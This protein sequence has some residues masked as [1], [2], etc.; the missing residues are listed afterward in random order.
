MIPREL[1]VTQAKALHDLLQKAQESGRTE[2]AQGLADELTNVQYVLD[3]WGEEVSPERD[4]LA[5]SCSW[6]AKAVIN[7]AIAELT[8]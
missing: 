1:M 3:H 6:I 4:E 8:R 7:Q 5:Q 2:V